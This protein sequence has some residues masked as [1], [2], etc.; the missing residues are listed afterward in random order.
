MKAQ[1]TRRESLALLAAALSTSARAQAWPSKPITMIVPYPAGG[2]TDAVARLV[3]EKLGKSLGQ[4]VIVDNKAGASGLLGMG[5]VAKAAPD[6]YTILVGIST[7][8]VINPFLFKKLPYDPNKDI[9][10]VSQIALSP[11]VLLANPSLP[12][13]DVPSLLKYIGANKGKLSYGSYGIGSASH[14]SGAHLSQIADGDMTHVPYKGEA[15]LIQDLIGGQVLMG[16]TGGLQARSMTDAGKLKAIGVTGDKRTVSLPNVPTF[17]E[18][19]VKDEVFRTV[20]WYAMAAPGG[21]P[22]A[23]IQRLA[24]EVKAACAL[25]DVRERIANLGAEAVGR[26]PEEFTA[27]AKADAVVWGRLV[28]QTGASLD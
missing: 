22:K 21:T 26:G 12:A 9:A 7:N 17:A 8:F 23:V 6:G 25:P 24:D 16:F 14:L 27:I 5:A 2:G 18:Q 15:P 19:G 28:K 3:A 10:L 11:I 4:N 13:N 20:G 1:L